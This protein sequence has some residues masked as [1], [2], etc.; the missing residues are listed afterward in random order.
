MQSERGDNASFDCVLDP[1]KSETVGDGVDD[2]I[3]AL[4]H[5]PDEL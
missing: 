4:L 3:S 2:A 1:P 5:M